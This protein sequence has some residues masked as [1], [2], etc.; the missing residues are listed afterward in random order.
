[1]KNK[2]RGRRGPQCDAIRRWRARRGRWGC[3]VRHVDRVNSAIWRAWL[4]IVRRMGTGAWLLC[5]GFG[6]RACVRTGPGRVV[7]AG[8]ER[9]VGL[10]TRVSRGRCGLVL[11]FFCLSRRTAAARVCLLRVYDRGAAPSR[12]LGDSGSVVG[13]VQG[14]QP[15]IDMR[16]GVAPSSGCWRCGG[17][18]LRTREGVGKW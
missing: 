2:A 7:R 4:P 11:A 17:R 3:H 6:T 13:Y 16:R 14:R 12:S 10:M 18:G 8:G 15:R 5:D 1:M 9:E